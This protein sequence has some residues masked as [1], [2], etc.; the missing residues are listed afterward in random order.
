MKTLEETFIDKTDWPDGPWQSEP[1][2]AQWLDAQTGL[3][4]LAVRNAALGHWCG[5]V[6][7][8]QGHPYYEKPYDLLDETLNVHNGVTY[9]E[10]CA[11]NI[12]HV[13]EPGERGDVWWIGFHCGG[14]S[15]C[16]PGL[17]GLTGG[18]LSDKDAYKSL[19]FVENECRKLAKQLAGIK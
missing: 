19:D 5:Y 16:Q 7:V 11:E 10:K 17:A 18:N 6:G 15:E 4:C 3:P 14:F 12:C 8:S 9:S 13:V 1:D 2:K